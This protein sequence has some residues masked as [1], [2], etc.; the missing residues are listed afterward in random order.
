MAIAN[1]LYGKAEA[2]DINYHT[3]LRNTWAVSVT[4]V[5]DGYSEKDFWRNF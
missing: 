4:D 5:G 3:E 2:Y 1:A